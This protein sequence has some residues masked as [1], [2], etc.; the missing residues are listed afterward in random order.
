MYLSSELHRKIS[1]PSR[2]VVAVRIEGTGCYRPERIVTSKGID[3]RLGWQDGHTESR[4]RI[5]AR[6]VAEGS[7]TS[8][9]MA[10]EAAQQAL[11]AAGVAADQVDLVWLPAA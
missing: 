8:S 9:F 10:A 1:R 4:Y 7:E 6:G 11:D 3:R 2:P 5:H